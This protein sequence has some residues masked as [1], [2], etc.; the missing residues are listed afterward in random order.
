M[1]MA[2]LMK[3]VENAREDYEILRVE[4][5][6]TVMVNGFLHENN[7]QIRNLYDDQK[8][9][10]DYINQYDLIDWFDTTELILN[11]THIQIA[12]IYSK[13]PAQE[14]IGKTGKSIDFL[15]N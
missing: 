12:F 11:E 13:M 9:S 7:E 4:R 1:F 6:Q 10:T 8:R 15:D 3:S 5:Y 14:E 2:I